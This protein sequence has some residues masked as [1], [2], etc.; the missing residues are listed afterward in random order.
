MVQL[1]FLRGWLEKRL[2]FRA[3]IEPDSQD[4]FLHVRLIRTLPYFEILLSATFKKWGA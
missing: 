2:V 1:F 3:N 4:V